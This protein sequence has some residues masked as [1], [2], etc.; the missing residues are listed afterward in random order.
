[1]ILYW[2]ASVTLFHAGRFGA[3]ETVTEC[4]ATKA[5]A[6]AWVIRNR[7]RPDGS[8]HLGVIS[9]IYGPAD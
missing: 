2:R 7:R 4:F 5:E 1:M 8:K 6:R 3:Y 9:P